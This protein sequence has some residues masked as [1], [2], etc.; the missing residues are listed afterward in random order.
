MRRDRSVRRAEEVAVELRRAKRR[1]PDLNEPQAQATSGTPPRPR[2]RSTSQRSG[3]HVR[4]RRPE[5]RTTCGA[6][7]VDRG[8]PDVSGRRRCSRGR[9]RAGSDRRARARRMLRRRRRRA[10]RAARSGHPGSRTT[11]LEPSAPRSG[12]ARSP[13]PSSDR[14]RS[15]AREH[16]GEHRRRDGE[17]ERRHRARRCRVAGAAARRARR[18]TSAD[19]TTRPSRRL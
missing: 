18:R 15:C 2:S 7:P 1:R 9:G 4:G 10:R 17:P 3:V 11:R 16:A 13:A 8:D 6:R 19:L 12:C 5:R 14:S